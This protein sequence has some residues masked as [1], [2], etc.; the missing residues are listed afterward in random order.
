[1]RIFI[2]SC[3]FIFLAVSLLPPFLM[4]FTS[5]VPEG[6]LFN[7]TIEKTLADFEAP[8]VVL[9]NKIRPLKSSLNVIQLE[10]NSFAKIQP[11][12][13]FVGLGFSLGSSDINMLKFVCFK[14]KN[15]LPVLVR[16]GFKDIK[17]R[18]EYFYEQQLP[19]NQRWSIQ[20]IAINPKTLSLDTLHISQLR[21][22]FI[23]RS[24][25]YM[26]DVSFVNSFPTFYNFIKV[27]G[28][29]NFGR[30]LLNSSIVSVSVVI[31]NIFFC[32]LIGYCFARKSFRFKETLFALILGTMMIPPQVTIIPVFILM[33]KLNLIDTYWALILP[34]LVSPFGVF[35]MRQYIEQ[36][37]FELDQAAYADGANDFQIFWHVIFPLCKPSIAVLG[38][39]TFVLTWNDLFYPLILTTSREMRTVQIGLALYQKLNVFTW[40]TLMAASTLAGLPIIIVFLIFEKKIISG[41]LEGAVKG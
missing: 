21:I 7:R 34:N 9:L 31:G 41:I 5:F 15:D 22:E 30:Y 28:S 19:A 16:V 17:E 27:L 13:E 3:L 24:E 10:N 26:D 32:A 39:N 8:R 12:T 33:K 4:I 37:P 23:A 11:S 18:V 38:I 40:P 2:Y 14:I 6:D 29:D 25:I 36:L 35:L 1:M 20:K